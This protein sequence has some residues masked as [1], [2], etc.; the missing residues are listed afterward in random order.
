MIK[1][2]ANLKFEKILIKYFENKTIG[3]TKLVKNNQSFLNYI[4]CKTSFFNYKNLSYTPFVNQRLWHLYHKTETI[5]ICRECGNEVKFV[6]FT[7]GYLKTCKDTKCRYGDIT[8]SNVTKSNIKN[9]GCENPLQSK[10]IKE[11]IK[12]TNIEKYGC[13]NPF[14][15]EEIKEKSKATMLK[16]YGTE[17]YTSSEEGKEKI[18]NTNI[19][20]YGA[21]RYATTNECKEKVKMGNIDKYGKENPF[22]V[23]EFKEKAKQTKLEKYGDYNYNNREGAKITT[24]EKYGTNNYVES[25]DFKEKSK[26]TCI[27][28]YGTEYAMQ[29]VNIQ[30]RSLKNSYYLK[31]YIFPSGRKEKI[32]GYE[33]RTINM[34]LTAYT[35]NDIIIKNEEIE[36][37]TGK[38]SYEMDGKIHRYFPD[39]YIVSENKIYETKSTWTFE[40]QLKKNIL[41]KEAAIKTGLFFEF[42]IYDEDKN[43]LNE[44]YLNTSSI[45]SNDI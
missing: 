39:M 9:F 41:K 42:M 28:K 44:S 36:K 11:R 4:E 6:N 33:D 32:Q 34:L 29:N 14:Q 45:N 38:I 8:K 23:E 25:N 3:L 37:Y 10:E 22:Q 19:K 21:K 2:T 35:E 20:K 5:P 30:L 13:E 12:K 43:L 17:H 24:I 27:E 7:V 31:E 16:K 1:E 26:K 40:S 15:S 18:N